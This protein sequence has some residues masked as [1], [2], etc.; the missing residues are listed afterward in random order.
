MDWDKKATA[1]KTWKNAKD[2]F[3]KELP[4]YRNHKSIEAKQA[5]FG[6][7]NQAKETD[8]QELIDCTKSERSP[9]ETYFLG[10]Q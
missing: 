10:I 8:N 9:P 1:D 5:G 2:H 3:S 6:S 7:T 4:N